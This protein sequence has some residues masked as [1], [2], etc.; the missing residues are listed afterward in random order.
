[1][2]HPDINKSEGAHDRAVAINRAYE[3]YQEQYLA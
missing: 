2:F 1:M 3:Q